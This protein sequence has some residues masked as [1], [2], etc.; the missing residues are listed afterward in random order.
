MRVEVDGE[1]V[2]GWQC[3]VLNSNPYTFVGSRAFD[4]DPRATL[5]AR[6]TLVV[7]TRFGALDFLSLTT[8]ALRGGGVAGHRTVRKFRGFENARREAVRPLP[9]LV[10]GEDLG[11]HLNDRTFTVADTLR[12]GCRIAEALAA[13][14]AA[15]QDASL[16]TR[17]FAFLRHVDWEIAA[18]TWSIFKAAARSVAVAE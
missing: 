18:G 13:A 5:D 9:W 1:V 8:A 14:Q 2:E 6:P 3:L 16:F 4:V 10:D 7:A 12:L 11:Q 15:I 17:P